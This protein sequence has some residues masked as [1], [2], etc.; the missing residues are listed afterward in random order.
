[1][2]HLA[3]RA[4]AAL[5]PCLVLAATAAA[6]GPTSPPPPP[7]TGTVAWTD[8]FAAGAAKGRAS[9][10]LLFVL[11]TR[12]SPPCIFCQKLEAAIWSQP[13]SAPLGERF[14]AVRMLGGND[15]TPEVEAFLERYEVEGF[16]TLLAMTPDGGV[17]ARLSGF[18]EAGKPITPGA[19]V[20]RMDQA[21]AHEAE[22]AKFR[23]EA[24]AKGDARVKEQLAGLLMQRY[25]LDAAHEV[26]RQVVQSTP[27]ADAYG[28]LAGLQ[29]MTGRKAEL[30][31]TLET[32]LAKF[33]DH[34]ERIE[35]RISLRTADLPSR[36]TGPE[37]VKK[38]IAQH[39]AAFTQLLREIEPE[40]RPGDQAE[41]RYRLADLARQR[42][43]DA[44][45]KPQLQWIL[46]HDGAGRRAAHARY[47]L[48]VL[49]YRADDLDGAIAGL[50]HVLKAH[51][52]TPEAGLAAER[53][54][55]IKAE[56]DSR[57]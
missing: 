54:P 41:I 15:A 16:P 53:L 56:R 33:P 24:T 36:A 9:G 4:L 50:E 3:S 23:A 52:N 28:M 44:G 31:K 45:A 38:V 22:F 48:A 7:A 35:W 55:E 5:L 2:R 40:G 51:P 37:E 42:R 18:D 57:K 49:A 43:D 47:V 26:Y 12:K 20:E 34:P 21:A 11:V 6:D 14:V 29:A 1:V 8:G 39:E 17:V 13:G 30:K 10:K 46:D 25:E 27:T 32:M 19:M